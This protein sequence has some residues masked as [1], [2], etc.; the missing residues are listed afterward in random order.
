MR[1][2]EAQIAASDPVRPFERLIYQFRVTQ[3]EAILRWLDTCEQ[4]LT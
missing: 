2:L 4:T 1:D 3:I